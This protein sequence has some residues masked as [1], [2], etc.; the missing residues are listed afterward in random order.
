MMAVLQKGAL[1]DRTISYWQ[2]VWQRFSRQRV[3]VA[4]AFLV[5]VIVG[6]SLAAPVVAPYPYDQQFRKEGLTELGKPVAPNFRFLLGTDQLGR[7]LLSRVLWGGRVSLSVGF[8]AALLSVLVGLLIGGF[9]GYAGGA[10]DFAI[11]RLVDLMMSVPSFL[12]M[13]MLV[14]ILRPGVWVVVFVIAVFGWTGYAR[15]FRSQVVSVKEQ[16]YVLAAR[17]IGVPG[18]RIFFVHILPHLAP[19][20]IV[21]VTLGIPS[22][23]FAETG[24]SF[25][26]L[27]VPPPI[28]AWGGIMQSGISFYR[29]AP[30]IVL[31]PGLIIMVTVIA[32]TLVGNALREAMDPTMRGR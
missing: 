1:Q 15:N 16:D 4:A 23:I 13:L 25:L 19:L 29:A 11:M 32:L 3:A 21:Y 17:A 5:V 8:T 30:W 28:P 24:L 26:G 9:S 31:T 7:D 20:S 14:V 22:T 2:D 18:R 12:M 27:G 6:L 10:I